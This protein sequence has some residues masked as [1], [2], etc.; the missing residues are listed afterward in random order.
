MQR[1]NKN[2]EEVLNIWLEW[3]LV[4]LSIRTG[5]IFSCHASVSWLSL[6]VANLEDSFLTYPMCGCRWAGSSPMIISVGT[7]LLKFNGAVTLTDN[8]ELHHSGWSQV[9][10]YGSNVLIILLPVLSLRFILYSKLFPGPI[11]SLGSGP[12]VQTVTQWAALKQ[13]CWF[14]H[15]L[16]MWYCRYVVQLEGQAASSSSLRTFY[17]I[18]E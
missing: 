6:P 13:H 12:S 2:H 10:H 1:W 14:S 15:L 4:C 5:I 16:Q 3:I 11:Q 7:A 9:M 17:R 8:K 18:Q